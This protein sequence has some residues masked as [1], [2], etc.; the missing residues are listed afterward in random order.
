MKYNFLLFGILML[1][2]LACEKPT[3]I[4]KGI[5]PQPNEIAYGQGS[6]L[7]NTQTNIIHDDSEEG[8]QLARP[9]RTKTRGE[10]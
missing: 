1:L 8:Q 9:T 7:I 6:F 4:A 5:I 2:G 3:P 10:C